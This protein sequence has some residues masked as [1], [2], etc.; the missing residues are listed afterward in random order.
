MG[1]KF[2]DTRVELILDLK[3]NDFFLEKT[4]NGKVS[5]TTGKGHIP[6]EKQYFLSFVGFRCP[7]KSSKIDRRPPSLFGGGFV[8][9][10]KIPL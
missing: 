9:R 8:A 5:F 4:Y 1:D 7:Q 6:Q 10:L 2:G 3:K